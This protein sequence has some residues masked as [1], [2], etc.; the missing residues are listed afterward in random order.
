MPDNTPYF[1]ANRMHWDELV[2]IHL[3]TTGSDGYNVAALKRGTR[4][5]HAVE[6]AE[7]GSVD[8]LDVLHL[9][10]HFGVDSLILA[11]RGARVIGLDYSPAAIAAARGLA[12]ETGLDARFVEG[13]VYDAP[14]LIDG[15]FD[16]VFV[17][18]GTIC[19]LPDLPAWAG[20]VAHFLKPG[21]RFY[22]CDAHPA[23]RVFDDSATAAALP[24]G[25]LRVH[26]PYFHRAEP[27]ANTASVDYA[28]PTAEIRNQRTYEWEH[29]V[30]DIV[31]AVIGAGLQ[32]DWLHEHDEI[33]WNLLPI[34]VP[35][36]QGQYRWPDG[37]MP[38]LPLSLSLS[39]R[40]P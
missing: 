34:L 8:G 28:D 33:A 12:A 27:T 25:T 18:W 2:G 20:V 9:Q 17:T 29:S 26:Y 39:A 38:K 5:L 11:Q 37:F 36:G 10:C 15:R 32:L 22:F 13:N 16:L 4:T 40:K 7:I 30:S 24:L 23:A 21:G 6:E 19:W 14:R 35:G 1:D 3:G 31:N